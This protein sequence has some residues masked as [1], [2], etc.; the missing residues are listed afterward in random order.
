MITNRTDN[1]IAAGLLI[2]VAFTALSHGAVEAWSVAIFELIILLLLLLWVIKSVSEKQFEIKIPLTALPI[3]AFFLFGI[4]QSVVLTDES[5]QINS[6]SF[7]SEATK[8][9]VK[10]LFFLLISHIIAANFFNSRERLQKLTVFLTIFGFA[11]AI[12][13]LLQYFTWNGSIYW[14]RPALVTTKGVIGPFVNHN[15]FAGYLELIVPLPFALIVT[16]AVNRNR[17]L[18][19]FAAVVMAVALAASLSRGGIISLAGGLLF[20]FAAGIGYARRKTGAERFGESP[21]VGSDGNFISSSLINFGAIAL[22]IGAFVFGVLWIGSDPV[23]ERLTKNNVIS[24]DER[25]E[26]FENSRG[27]I[28]KN[29]LTM[30]RMNPVSGVGIGA[31]E[32]AY[33]Q[34]SS[35]NN[36]LSQNVDRAHNDYLQ[37]LS[38]TGLIGAAIAFSF[39]LSVLFVIGRSLLRSREPFRAGLAIGCGAAIFSMMI[40]SIF[41]FNLQIPST[42]LLFLILT[43]VSANLSAL[44]GKSK[45]RK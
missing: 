3:S 40:H 37:I 5:G 27:W 31:Y 23:I 33:P 16:G 25:A 17:I 34:Y 44:S 7:D 18:Y 20:V 32:T 4:I 26:S 14:L 11:L 28:W 8:S 22:I 19:G 45:E 43:A 42:A 36:G 38:D 41:D 1:L 21:G 35:E 6:L 15:H 30:F 9:A 13:G 10:I 2:A 24:A 12:F 29:S 39:I